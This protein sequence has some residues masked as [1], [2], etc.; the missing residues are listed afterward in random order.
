MCFNSPGDGLSPG[1]CEGRIEG[2]IP[3]KRALFACNWK[4][5]T[6]G[7]SGKGFD[8]WSDQRTICSELACSPHFVSDIYGNLIS[9]PSLKLAW[10]FN[11]NSVCVSCDG[12]ATHATPLRY[13]AGKK[14]IDE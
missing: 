2:S 13:E 11:M 4:T 9:F 12:L 5:V 10:F 7:A 6:G 8:S 3:A 14:T 1:N